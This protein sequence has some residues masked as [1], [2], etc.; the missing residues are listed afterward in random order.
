MSTLESIADGVHAWIQPPGTWWINNA[1]AVAGADGVVLIDTCATRAR[2]E[3]FL[4]AVAA[5]TGDRPIRM[6][7]NTHLHGDHTY[8]NAVLPES[9]VIVAHELTRTGMLADFLL[10]ATPPIWSPTPD[11]G[12]TRIRPPSI[13]LRDRAVL[14]SGSRR[15]ELHHPGYPAHTPG[16]VVAWLP[17]ERVLFTGDLLFHQVTPLVFMGSLP[18]ALRSLQWLAGFDAAVVVPGHG[19]LI[20]GADLPDVLAAHE[21]YYRFVQDTADAADGRAPLAVARD[22]DLGEFATWP[23]PERLVLNLHRAHADATDTPLDVLAAFTDAVT[24]HGGPLHC[25]V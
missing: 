16:D 21:R 17:E 15:I 18:G 14:Y 23:D 24:W 10:T 2:T 13:T 3:R 7:V 1:G 20:P 19:Q 6:A 8:G 12:V 11:W 22:V 4:A 5:A 25:T 9:T